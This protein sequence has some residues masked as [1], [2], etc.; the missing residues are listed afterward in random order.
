MNTWA[1]IRGA[2][3]LTRRNIARIIAAIAAA[4]LSFHTATT[5]LSPADEALNRRAFS[6][7]DSVHHIEE[8]LP[9]TESR[10]AVSDHVFGELS[11]LFLTFRHLLP[12]ASAPTMPRLSRLNGSIAS[13]QRPATKAD[14]RAAVKTILRGEDVNLSKPGPHLTH[15]K[16]RQIAAAENYRKTHCGC[17]LHNACIKSFVPETG[18]YASGKSLYL[19]MLRANLS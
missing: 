4:I 11:E 8:S 17:T 15:A 14:L 18:G 13:S 3:V 9:A 16:R 6:A 7:L 1:K 12:G 5:T 10:V 19:A 2:Y